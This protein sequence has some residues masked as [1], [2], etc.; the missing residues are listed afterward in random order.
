[1]LNENCLPSL[2]QT[3]DSLKPKAKEPASKR[4]LDSWINQIENSV[5]KEQGGRLSWLVA[6]TVVTAALQRAVDAQ[7]NSRFLL[8]GGTLLQHRLGDIAR[9]TRDLDG[10][11][12]GDIDEY[13]DILDEM[14]DEQWGPLKLV[15]GEVETINTPAKTIKPRAFT[16]SIILKGDTWRKVKVEISPD[17]GKAGLEQESV[18]P[19][20]FA[21]LGLPTPDALAT[22]AM[23]YQIAQK[24][25]SATDPHDPPEYV[26]ERP[27]DVVDLL[28]IRGLA[29]ATG[30]PTH[31][32]INDAIVDIF[33]ARAKE[34]KALDRL[35]RVW[36]AR[37]TVLPHWK[38][39]Y[40]DAAKKAGL[41][42]SLEAAI[43]LVNSWLDEIESEAAQSKL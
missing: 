22:L 15:R 1:M 4:V 32:E 34:A 31:K 23:R 19:P 8:K 3:L 40:L 13:L 21:G 41:S 10:L 42:L 37:I 18:S 30:S 14:L 36:P 27:R 6:S 43:E 24:V 33:S 2:R 9:A 16:I 20:C 26:N 39:D 12:R 28:L 29:K 5:A 35:V 7:G 25:H 38:N 17:E 11:V